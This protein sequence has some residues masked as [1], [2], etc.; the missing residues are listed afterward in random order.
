MISLAWGAMTVGP[1]LCARKFKARE[2]AHWRLRKSRGQHT[3]GV[4][5]L[6]G[7]SLG[8]YRIGCNSFG[9]A[10]A[11]ILGSLYLYGRAVSLGAVTPITSNPSCGCISLLHRIPVSLLPSAPL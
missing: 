2:E 8:L 1:T 10:E 7:N 6:R 4:T 3:S 9:A 5:I 11:T